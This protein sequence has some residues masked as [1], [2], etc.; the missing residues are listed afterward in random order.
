MAVNKYRVNEFTPNAN[1]T[2]LNH[3][4]YAQAVI[5]NV[6]TNKELA[7]KI[8]A[9]GISRAAEIKSILEEAANVILEEV[10]ENNRVQLES[11]DGVLVSI[12]PSV[13]GSISDAV[14]QANPE[15]YPGKTRAEEQMLTPDMLT[16]KIGATV[17]TK[18]TK[19]FAMN[20]Q[21]QKVAYSATQQ[22]ADPDGG[23]SQQGGG[24]TANPGENE[25]D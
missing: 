18:F 7:K 19:Q 2:T 23:T 15:K 20:K 13:S 17:G 21:A 4:F 24:T 9:R 12:Y 1:Q 11:G 6:I 10:M 5:D 14:V 25:G 22:T 3:S 16:W 8:E